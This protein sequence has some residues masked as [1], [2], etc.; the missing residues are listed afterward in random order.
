MTATVS[1]DALSA[2]VEFLQAAGTILKREQ[3]W[4]LGSRG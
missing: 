2:D 4:H 3:N 1:R